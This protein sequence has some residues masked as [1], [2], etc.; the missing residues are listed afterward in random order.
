MGRPPRADLHGVLLE[1]ARTEFAR[2]GVERARVED[3]V[4]RA[5]VSKGAFYLHFESKEEAL[6]EL[7]QRFFGAMEDQARGRKEAEERFQRAHANL[8]GAA[9]YARQLEFDCEVDQA[10]L[11][12]LWRNREILAAIEGA[13]TAGRFR[14]R[15]AEFRRR[16]HALVADRMAE[17]QARGAIRRDLEPVVLG[18]VLVGAYEYF[19]RRMLTMPTRPDFQGWIR[20]F[21][22]I[23]YDGLLPRPGAGSAPSPSPARRGAASPRRH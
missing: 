21:L 13:G 18:D 3:V 16:M 11:E 2:R 7:L 6:D 20:S 12:M 9:L 15:L 5:G 4:R 19:A 14:D 10:L 8:R 23:L 22:A 17:K 1:A